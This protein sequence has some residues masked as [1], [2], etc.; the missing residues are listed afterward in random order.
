MKY[1]FEIKIYTDGDFGFPYVPKGMTFDGDYRYELRKEYKDRE[2]AMEDIED[3]CGFLLYGIKTNR[4]YVKKHWHDCLM[5]FADRLEASN[6]VHECIVECMSGNYDGTEISFYTE[7]DYVEFGF[8]VSDEEK[9]LIVDNKK[10]VTNEMIKEV[11]LD[12]F[13]NVK[14]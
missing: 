12:L 13:K 6:D 2:R 7:D 14:S 5:N 10:Y 3:I 8:Y 11:V 4:D 1:V 9:E